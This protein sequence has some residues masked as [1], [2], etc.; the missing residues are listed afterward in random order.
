MK[1]MAIVIAFILGLAAY[2]YGLN[3]YKLTQCDFKAPFKAETIRTIGLIPMIGPLVG[4]IEI[5]D[6]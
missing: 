3:V 6:K 1:V 2:G 5:E 4:Y